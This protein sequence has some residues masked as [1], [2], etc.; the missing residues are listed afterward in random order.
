MHERPTTYLDTQPDDLAA[1]RQRARDAGRDGQ[2]GRDELAGRRRRAASASPEL[3]QA[4]QVDEDNARW[5]RRRAAEKTLRERML[6]GVGKAAW[7]VSAKPTGLVAEAASSTQG[8]S[9]C[10]SA[11]APASRRCPRRC[12]GGRCG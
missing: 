11:T 12:R 3:G 10:C 2:L 4:K 8:C 7:S 5:A 6:T 1:G 9:R